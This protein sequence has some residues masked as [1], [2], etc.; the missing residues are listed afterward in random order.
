MSLRVIAAIGL[1]Y[2][3]F[4]GMPDIK[5]PN[6]PSPTPQ[7]PTVD[8]PTDE[9][10][11]A[12]SDVADICEEMDAFDRLVWM[13][14]WE[15]AADIV[16][17]EDSDVQ[18]TFENTLGLRVFASNVFDVAWRRLAKA[19]GKYRGLDAAVEKAFETAVG[20]D[21]KPWS[22]DLQDTVVDLFDAMAWA[23][24]RSE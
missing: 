5:L 14:T 17:G 12:V 1:L 7:R 2:V 6:V 20:N 21:I 23:G 3:A 4:Y 19:S 22:D 15:D 8:E 18:V 9:L 24:A 10:Q 11:R 16:A 13:A